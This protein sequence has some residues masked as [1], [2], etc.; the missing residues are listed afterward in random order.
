MTGAKSPRAELI[1]RPN[2]LKKK[3][4]GS[5]VGPAGVLAGDARARVRDVLQ[6]Y[7]AR[8]PE[9]AEKNIRRLASLLSQLKRTPDRHQELIAQI[10]VEA[11]EI[12]GQ[13]ET[14]DFP[15]LTWL[16]R[17]LY[18]LCETA[19]PEQQGRLMLIRINWMERVLRERITGYGAWQ[20][21][22]SASYSGK[23][24]NCCHDSV[25]RTP[26]M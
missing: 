26:R 16:G 17:S 10:R 6:E 12:M 24:R 5:E 7:R 1:T 15:R 19:I 21:A 14:L 3:V 25:S 4:S 11:L 13:A 9:V 18:D 23:F 22:R 20:P 2:S 8:Y